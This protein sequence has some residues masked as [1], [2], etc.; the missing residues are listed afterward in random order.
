MNKHWRSL[1]FLELARLEMAFE[2]AVQQLDSIVDR[3]WR[4]EDA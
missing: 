4:Y 2:R 1:W 3:R